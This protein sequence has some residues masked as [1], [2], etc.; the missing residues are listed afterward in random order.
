MVRVR[1]LVAAV[2]FA[3]VLIIGAPFAVELRGAIATAFPLQARAILGGM[4]A[5]AIAAALMAA[6]ARIR[7]RRALRYVAL[8]TALI[9]GALFA[10]VLSTGDPDTDVVETFH[11]VEY[12]VLTLLL[13][14]AWRPID[15]VS[16]LVLPVLAGVL[17]GTLDEWFQWFIPSRVGEIRDVILDC[18]A[19]ACGLLFSI[20]IDPPAHFTLAMRRGSAI[21]IGGM[22]AVAT[23]VFAAFLQTVHVGYDA[24]NPR[25]GVF[26]SRYTTAELESAARERAERWRDRPFMA[27]GRVSRE[28]QYLSEALWHVRR[29]NQAASAG[30][31][32]TAWRENRIL[33][34]FYTPVL[35]I[36]T[37]LGRPGFRWPAEQRVDVERR[38]QDDGGP[39]VSDA[40]PYSIYVWPKWT[41]WMV[42]VLVISIT[43]VLFLAAER[44]SRDSREPS[45]PPTKG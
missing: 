35:E 24:G 14:L 37:Y 7:D 17:V 27:G 12:G 41:F 40:E 11:F 39:Y 43:V 18:A 16:V 26:R 10:R 25:V 45:I 19:V 1:Y 31:V 8:G 38:A 42:V 13:Y 32:F 44:R 34:T 9:V 3:I 4:V 2:G 21:R 23:L 36:P 5:I 29:R 22:L 30:D 15:D 20:G 28:D 6:A 33:E